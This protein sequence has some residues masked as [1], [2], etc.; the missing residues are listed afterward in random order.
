L[1][2]MI[3]PFLSGQTFRVVGQTATHEG[4]EARF[5]VPGATSAAPIGI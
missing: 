3:K 4:V 2:G 5:A 1:I